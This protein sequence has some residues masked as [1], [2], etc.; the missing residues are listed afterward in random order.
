MTRYLNSQLDMDIPPDQYW[1]CT[2]SIT[3]LWTSSFCSTLFV[4]SMTFDRFYGIIRPHK[5]ASF[6]TVKRAK[7]TITCIICLSIFYHVPHLFITAQDGRRCIPFGKAV[8]TTVGRI[9]YWSAFVV[10]FAIPFVCL[11]IMNSFI[12][13]T[14]RNRSK[15]H[16]GMSA[17]Q[18]QSQNQGHSEGRNSKIK[19]SEMQIYIILLLV[20]F[21]FLVLMTPG[22]V[23]FVYVMLVNYRRTPQSYAGYIF[24]HSF[25]QKIFYTN[26]GINFFLYVLSGK[27]FR[28]DL[29]ALF[30]M[31]S[32]PSCDQ[33]SLASNTV[34]TI[35][36]H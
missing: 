11:L 18:G 2:L 1:Y 8:G 29:V 23:L 6:N 21:A 15:S 26:Y 14:I 32:A 33:S 36:A 22:Y 28:S 19:S 20:T 4:L 13:H 24:L 31:K 34:L 5:A 10:L 12:I 7:I 17:N 27:K 9:Y 16:L 25:S 35:V 3:V 30:R